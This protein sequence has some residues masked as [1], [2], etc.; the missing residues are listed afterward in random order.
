MSTNLT[1]PPS[2]WMQVATNVLDTSGDFTITATNAVDPNAP[3]SF[4]RL[5]L[6]P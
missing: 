1:L 6:L 4:Y 3:Q 5:E 2:Q